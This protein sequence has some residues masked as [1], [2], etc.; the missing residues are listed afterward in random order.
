MALS[1]A[2]EIDR[3]S[4]CHTSYWRPLHDG[5]VHPAYYV[6][7]GAKEVAELVATGSFHLPDRDVPESVREWR[8]LQEAAVDTI[9]ESVDVDL[10]GALEQAVERAR[11][12]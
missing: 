1:A 7:L 4:V 11:H 6:M 9:N 10:L 3:N 2:T 8:K 5:S 12:A